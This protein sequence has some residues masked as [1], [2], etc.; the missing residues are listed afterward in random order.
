MKLWEL[1]PVPQG[2][3]IPTVVYVN[4]HGYDP[5]TGKEEVETTVP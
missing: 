5:V 4:I 2:A 3:W 1:C